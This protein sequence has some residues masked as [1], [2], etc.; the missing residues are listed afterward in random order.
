MILRPGSA[1]TSQTLSDRWE[2]TRQRKER[3]M[4]EEKERGRER[5][6]EKGIRYSEI[7]ASNLKISI[8][9]LMTIF[10]TP[11]WSSIRNKMLSS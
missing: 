5:A 1:G 4:K 11:V 9:T 7:Q 10:D 8:A 6:R 3:R 2:K